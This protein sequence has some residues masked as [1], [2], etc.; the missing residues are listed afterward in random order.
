MSLHKII[1]L[2]KLVENTVRFKSRAFLSYLKDLYPKITLLNFLQCPKPKGLGFFL[3]KYDRNYKK[4]KKK[5]RLK[6]EICAYEDAA[7]FLKPKISK[8]ICSQ[9]QITSSSKNLK[10]FKAFIQ[11]NR[12]SVLLLSFFLKEWFG[13]KSFLNRKN[14]I[15][16]LQL[17]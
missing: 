8:N 12:F 11:G 15:S 17:C 2:K 9:K 7:N 14:E 4:K 3:A 13:K 1:D 16:E 10:S 5:A 6:K